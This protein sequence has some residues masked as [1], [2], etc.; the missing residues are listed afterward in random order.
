MLLLG[1]CEIFGLDQSGGLSF[2]VRDTGYPLVSV[3]GR[4]P[5]DA[6]REAVAGRRDYEVLVPPEGEGRVTAAL[7][8]WERSAA[9]LHLLGDEA[10]LPRVPAGAVR[11][12]EPSELNAMEGVPR[13]LREEFVMAARTSPVAASFEGGRPVAFCYADRTET[14]WDVSIDTLEG[15]RRRGHAARCVAYMIEH[16]RPLRPVWGAENT[17]LA[18]LG[19]AARLGFVPVDEVLLFRER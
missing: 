15:Y 11:L 10:R 4:P 16:L 18:S 14:L 8:G 12:L 5:E 9:T 17:N 13:N 3:V 6:I 2:V 7:P 19:L 1:E